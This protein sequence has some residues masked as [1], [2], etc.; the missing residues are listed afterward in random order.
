LKEEEM[1]MLEAFHDGA[2]R[3]IVGISR[4]IVHDERLTKSAVRKFF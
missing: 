3:R 4:Q 1:R 2:I